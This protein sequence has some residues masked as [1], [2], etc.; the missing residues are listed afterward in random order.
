MK[1]YDLPEDKK[2]N[3]IG[4]RFFVESKKRKD[5]YTVVDVNT[6]TNSRG[7]FVRRELVCEHEFMGQVIRSYE[8]MTKLLMSE[9]IEVDN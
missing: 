8:V 9:I 3:P 6:T 4:I 2:S 7:Q 5:L 1:G